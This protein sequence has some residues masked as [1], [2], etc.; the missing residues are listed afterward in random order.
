MKLLSVSLNAIKDEGVR[1]LS[2][3]VAKME[4]LR[5]QHCDIT[6]HGISLLASAIKDLRKPVM[7]ISVL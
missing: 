7:F 1:H 3:C 2:S 5:I 4:K 6:Y